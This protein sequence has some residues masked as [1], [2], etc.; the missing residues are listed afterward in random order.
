MAI[1]D[2]LFGTLLVGGSL[3]GIAALRKNHKDIKE[4]KLEEARRKNTPCSFPPSLTYDDFTKKKKKTAKQFKRLKV[5]SIDN[6]TVFLRYSSQSGISKYNASV[7]YNDYGKI[8]GEYWIKNENNDSQLPEA[9]A[10]AMKEMI[11][12]KINEDQSYS[13]TSNTFYD[14][15]QEKNPPKKCLLCGYESPGDSIF[16]AKCGNKFYN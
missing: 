7:D 9:F 12:C 4:R 10:K 3:I 14:S 2:L 15:A 5:S 16:C 11:I 1:E 13:S 6:T 8:T